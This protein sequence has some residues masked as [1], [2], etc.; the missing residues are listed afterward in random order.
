MD[1][2]KVLLNNFHTSKN[3]YKVKPKKFEKLYVILI[4]V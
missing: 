1:F 4:T 2:Q 3:D